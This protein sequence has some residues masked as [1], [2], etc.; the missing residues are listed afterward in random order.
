MYKL[1]CYFF[2]HKWNLTLSYKQGYSTTYLLA[3]GVC[4]RC[5]VKKS[6]LYHEF[7]NTGSIEKRVRAGANE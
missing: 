5:G 4:S 2:G 7:K 6:G 1:I 3:D